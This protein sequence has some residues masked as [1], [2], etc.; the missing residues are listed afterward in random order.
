MNGY[1]CDTPVGYYTAR[2]IPFTR[3]GGP[4]DDYVQNMHRYDDKEHKTASLKINPNYFRIN[5]AI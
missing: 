2:G 1:Y 4:K 5:P 3:Q